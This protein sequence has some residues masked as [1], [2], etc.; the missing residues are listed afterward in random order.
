M[1]NESSPFQQNFSITINGNLIDFSTPKVMGILNITPDSFY[2]G[3]KHKN[4]K[5]IVSQAE[6]LLVEGADMLDLGAYSSRPGATSISFEEEK[7]RL[8]PSLKAIRKHF[9]EALISIDTF[10]SEIADVSLQEGVS[11]IND[12][13]AG[14]QDEKMFETVA[15]HNAPYILMHMRGNAQSM[16][17][18]TEYGDIENEVFK[19]LHNK[20]QLAYKQ[21][22]KYCIIDLGFG[23]AKNLNQNYLLLKNLAHFKKINCPILV[24]VSRKKMIQ[25]LVNSEAK[26]ALNGT[27]V[28]HVL[29]IQNGANILR[30]HDVKEAKEAIKIVDYYQNV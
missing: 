9:P 20:V 26:N 16:Q 8:L 22:V 4:E 29:A 11:I 14:E 13:S 2:D 21:G 18:L 19:Y 24:G 3:G 5:G 10:R 6:K 25:S 30:A 15:K 7:A 28:A 27:T 1:Q 12:I 23:F 17:S